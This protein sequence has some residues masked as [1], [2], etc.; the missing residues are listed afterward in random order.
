MSKILIIEDEISVRENIIDLLEA[1]GHE[2]V[3]TENGFLG[4]LWAIERSPDLI[5]CDVMMPKISGY[6]VLRALR[7]DPVTAKIPF[8][9]L[10]A[11]SEKAD[12]R[13]AMELGADDYL[14]KP[15]TRADLLGAI[16]IRL[17]RQRTL[18]QEN[19]RSQLQ[20]HDLQSKIQVLEHSVPHESQP[21]PQVQDKVER[22][23]AKIEVAI[24]LLKKLETEEQRDCCLSVLKDTC[25]EDLQMIYQLVGSY[26]LLSVQD[27]QALKLTV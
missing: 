19:N 24:S 6:E 5:I 26:D 4:L 1:E 18:M 2:V 12:I 10:T 15:Y 11:L 8:I 27:R 25:A 3:C 23:I 13:R 14:T 17:A 20:L 21:L 9:F 22:A 7:Q 16:S